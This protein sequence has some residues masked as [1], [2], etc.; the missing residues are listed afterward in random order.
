AG[1]GVPA[2]AERAGRGVGAAQVAAA[3]RLRVAVVD[4]VQGMAD[5][6]A[7][8][9]LGRQAAA[10]AAAEAEHEAALRRQATTA[11]VAGAAS[12]LLSQL[13]LVA[14]VLGLAVVGGAPA[15]AAAVAVLVTLAVFE[16][17]APLPLA[18]QLLGRTRAAARR[19]REVAEAAPA[20]LDPPPGR[21]RTASA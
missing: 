12:Q 21:R 5:L 14:V 7:N 18:W 9:A 17:V 15:V 19:V 1:V 20:V 16:A 3:A 11:A 2:L 10:I 4:L 8:Q 6:A 13:A